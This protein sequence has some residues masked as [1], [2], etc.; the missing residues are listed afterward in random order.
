M[1]ILGVDDFKAKI[2][3]GGARPNLFKAIINFPG[4]AG[5][6]VELTSFLC[7]AAQLPAS[8]LNPIQ[9]PFRGRALKVAGERTFLTWD[10]S[11]INDTDFN[12]R[13]AMERWMNGI[14]GHTVNSGLVNPTD[15]Q[16]DLIVEQLDRDGTILKT[17]NFTGAF[18]SAVGQIELSYADADTIETFPV[19]FEYQYWTSN[20]TT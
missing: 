8:T 15:Y 1:A 4:Y 11:I 13:N 7:T 10:V 12:P 14:A 2:R 16:A 6:D 5:G 20:T 19:T 17:Y 3:G 9:I 18:P